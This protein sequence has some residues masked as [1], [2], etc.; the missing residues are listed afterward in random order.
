ML[1]A[2]VIA[3][4]SEVSARLDE[5]N[6]SREE[7]LQVVQ[8]VVA[9]RAEYVEYYDPINA[10]GQFAYIHGTRELRS[11]L[12]PKGWVID[13]TD[14]VESTVNA[15]L[16]LRFIFQNVDRAADPLNDPK[17]ISKKGPASERIVE[18]AQAFLFPEFEEEERKKRDEQLIVINSSV[19]FFC[20]SVDGDNVAAELSRPVSIENEQFAGFAERIFIVEPGT[21]SDFDVSD[22]EGAADV[23]EPL[24][25]RK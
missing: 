17:S 16:G 3:D 23:A 21:W 6:L 18:N 12:L 19:W 11:V 25:T 2:K 22:D 20:V 5:F 7:L 14:N 8:A 9:A 1:E 13:R 24:V 4:Q 10:Q 15:E